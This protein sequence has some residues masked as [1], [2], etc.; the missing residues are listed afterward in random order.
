M[1]DIP[2]VVGYIPVIHE[3]NKCEH[4]KDCNTPE[5]VK[6]GYCYTYKRIE[7]N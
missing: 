4:K 2:G 3:C 5:Y 7:K 1:K 6:Q